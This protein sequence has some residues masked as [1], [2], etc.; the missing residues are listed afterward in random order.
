MLS[1]GTATRIVTASALA[2]APVMVRKQMRILSFDFARMNSFSFSLP[3]KRS[4]REPHS[5]RKSPLIRLCQ[6][7]KFRNE[8]H[9]P[10]LKKRGQG[11]FFSHSVSI[12]TT[13]YPIPP[14]ATV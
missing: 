3:I 11:R 5:L 12:R 10:S 8:D 9:S 1:V 7:G 4:H 13:A 6:R 14:Y 2:N